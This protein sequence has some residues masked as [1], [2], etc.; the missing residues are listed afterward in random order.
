[1]NIIIYK[2]LI[3]LETLIPYTLKIPEVQD[4]HKSCV[5]YACCMGG[6][7]KLNFIRGGGVGQIELPK[8][9]GGG[10]QRW[11]EGED[12]GVG[13]NTMCVVL[14]R[15]MCITAKGLGYGPPER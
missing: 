8:G 10:V 6:G 7:G 1:M 3:A 12:R 4:F 2:K 15:Y 5:L 11:G 13:N 14:R 9:G